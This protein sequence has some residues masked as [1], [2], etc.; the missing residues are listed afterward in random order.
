MAYC[1]HC[2]VK[3]GDG[4]KR[5]PLCQTPVYDP[6]EPRR[7]AAAPYPVRMPEQELKK[8][9]RFLLMLSALMLLMP[10]LL[11]FI[12]DFLISGAVTWSGYASGALVMLFTS[13]AVPL[14]ANKH[15]VYFAIASSFVCLNGYLM[16]VEHLSASG[17]WFFPIALPALTLAAVLIF[18]ITKLYRDGWLNKLTILAAFLAAIPAECLFIEWLCNLSWGKGPT[19]IWSPFVLAPCMFL[20]LALFFINGNRAVREEVRRRVHF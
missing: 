20:S 4:K 6:A 8:S 7:E 12:I 2:G 3:L 11:C 9:K 10:A 17:P 1:V 5:C 19:F 15:Q 14:Q 16:L 18:F 13:V